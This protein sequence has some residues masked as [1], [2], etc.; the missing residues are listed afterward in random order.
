MCIGDR[1]EGEGAVCC[2][3][4]CFFTLPALELAPPEL[5]PEL[6]EPPRKCPINAESSISSAEG[7]PLLRFLDAVTECVTSA[8]LSSTVPYSTRTPP[9]HD[10]A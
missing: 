3:F 6:L 10:A 9:T 2:C 8:G 7:A 5:E 1:E 4:F